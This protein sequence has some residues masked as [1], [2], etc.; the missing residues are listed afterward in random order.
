MWEHLYYHQKNEHGILRSMGIEILK[1]SGRTFSISDYSE[2][3][4]PE[5]SLNI[6]EGIKMP[7][8]RRMDTLPVTLTHSSEL[9][10]L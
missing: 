9:K 2:M 3:P 5:S 10:G 1:D 6:L 7:V 8:N 4:L